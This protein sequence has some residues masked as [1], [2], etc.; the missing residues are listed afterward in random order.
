MIIAIDIFVALMTAAL[1]WIIDRCQPPAARTG[2]RWWWL[3]LLAAAAFPLSELLP[4]IHISAETST[5]QQHFVG[6]G[7][8]CALLYTYCKLRF[9]WLSPWL[10]DLLLLFAFVSALGVANEL[11]E[12]LM[13]KV[14]H[15][16][17]ID[18][19]DTSWDLTANTTGCFVGYGLLRLVLRSV[20]R[21][22]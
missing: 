17:H 12:F 16:P 10:I 21:E 5:F 18:I 3:V 8:Y 1:P 20:R 4:N 11:V 14:G 19:S 13:V 7:F 2:R 6:G 15:I 22:L 9:N